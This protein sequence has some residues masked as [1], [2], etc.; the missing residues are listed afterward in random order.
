MART[1]K[2][3]GDFPILILKINGLLMPL[4][5][6]KPAKVGAL[7]LVLCFVV[8]IAIFLAIEI[9]RYNSEVEKYYTLQT[10]ITR[11]DVI[12]IFGRP[13][14]R[15]VR[16]NR[17]TILYY[18]PKS[19]PTIGAPNSID[20]FTGDEKNIPWIY[21]AFQ[22]LIDSKGYVRV[23]TWLGESSVLHGAPEQATLYQ[24]YGISELS[25]TYLEGCCT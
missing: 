16:F 20:F 22:I 1:S 11:N 15:E 6:K 8:A 5:L 18:I 3:I 12:S 4:Q 13:P 10:G 9:T 21:E 14:D 24:G 19:T 2:T 23:F 17:C 7:L 25:A